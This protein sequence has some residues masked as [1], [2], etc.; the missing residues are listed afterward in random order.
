MLSSS[1]LDMSD[2]GEPTPTMKT[3]RYVSEFLLYFS[4]ILGIWGG[5]FLPFVEVYAGTGMC[6][7]G[8]FQDWT[9]GNFEFFLNFAILGLALYW[10]ISYLLS[11][12]LYSRAFCQ[13]VC[14]LGLSVRPFTWP[15]RKITHRFSE[16]WRDIAYAFLI[17]MFIGTFA[18][19]VSGL[20]LCGEYGLYC[21]L[22]P[23][24]VVYVD[25]AN[26]IAFVFDNMPWSIIWFGS[27]LI[28][29]VILS[30]YSGGR[31]WC[32]YICPAGAF[33]G[34]L[35]RKSIYGLYR[36]SEKCIKCH[37]CEEVCTMFIMPKVIAEDLEEVP[38]QSCIGCGLCVD[39][40]PTGALTFGT[41][42][43]HN[44]KTHNRV[45]YVLLS[46]T[47]FFIITYLMVSFF[48]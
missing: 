2:L 10:L 13:Y 35:G 40:C 41:K 6:P 42:N 37:K 48:G 38:K 5:L 47:L 24:N 16:K 1:S 18:M 19:M 25:F 15:K 31:Y 17:V 30:L 44:L 14:P 33:L 8:L 45:K 43:H 36:D 11:A 26:P 21:T 12:I 23:F 28:L 46:I 39:A 4:L 32:A 7:F 20:R 9:L 34:L 22:C 27:F 29:V 3:V